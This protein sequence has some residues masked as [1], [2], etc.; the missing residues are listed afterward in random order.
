MAGKF[1]KKVKYQKK[2]FNIYKSFSD[3]FVKKSQIPKEKHQ[4]IKINNSD[5]ILKRTGPIAR[6]GLFSKFN[7]DDLF[8]GLFGKK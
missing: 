1:N 3:K 5:P 8:E 7:F 4:K 6:G 2:N